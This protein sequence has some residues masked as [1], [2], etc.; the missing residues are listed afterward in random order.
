MNNDCIQ[1]SYTSSYFSGIFAYRV[2]L[3]FN[4]CFKQGKKKFL[5]VLD[6]PSSAEAVSRDLRF[7]T[8][9][10]NIIEFPTWDVLPF[11]A[12]SP[13]SETVASRMHCLSQLLLADSYIAITN[14]SSLMQHLV[15]P[16]IFSLHIVSITTAQSLRRD[17]LVYALDQLGYTRSSIVEEYGQLAVRGAVVDFFS[18]GYAL[19]IRIELFEDRI[20]SI[21]LFEPST[22]RSTQSL[23][24]CNIL[25]ARELFLPL[26]EGKETLKLKVD[27]ECLQRAFIKMRKRCSELLLAQT[28][29]RSLEDAI[30][31]GQA[32]ASIEHLQGF[33][34]EE[35]TTLWSYLPDDVCVIMPSYETL[36]YE[37]KRYEEVVI[38]RSIKAREEGRLHTNYEDSYMGNKDF[39]ASILKHSANTICLEDDASDNIVPV[40]SNVRLRDSLRIS[41][42]QERPLKPLADEIKRR[43]ASNESVCVVVEHKQ[44]A[45]RV[46]DLLSAYDIRSVHIETSFASWC[47]NI[48]KRRAH[49]V[50]LLF[51][52]LGSGFYSQQDG[53]QIIVE[54]EV[55]PESVS[56]PRSRFSKSLRR[57]LGSISQLNEQDYVVHMDYGIGI[58]RGLRVLTIEGADSD[59]LE[60]E[61]AEQAKL[62]VP[63][64]NINKVQKY[65]GQDAQKIVLS[66]LGAKTWENTKQKVKEN[67]A[68]LAGQLLDVMAKRASVIGI[69]Y[70]EINE[71]DKEFADTFPFEPTPDQET[72]IEAVLNDMAVAKPMDRLICGDVGYGKTEVAMRAAFKAANSGRQVAILVPTTVLAEQHYQS[73][74]ERFCQTGIIVKCVSRFY[75]SAENKKTLEMLTSGQ[76]DIII[77]THRLLQKDVSFK[78]LGLLVIDEEHKFGVTH[79]EKLKRFRTEVDVLTLT[80]T[81]IPRTLQLSLSGIRELSLIETAPCDRQAI[82]TSIG[83]YEN[84]IVREAVLRETSRGGQV[85]Y[86]HNRVKDIYEIKKELVELLPEA[87]IAVAHG[88]MKEGELEKVMHSFIQK[89]VDVLLS[90]TIVESGLDIP[91]ANTI[92]IRNAQNFGLAEL[93]QL[94]GRVG[95]SSRRAYAY[96]LIEDMKELNEDTK[97][98]LDVLKSLDDLGVGFRLALQ[99]MEI[100]GAGNLLGKD[101]SGHVQLVGYELYSKILK[102][103]VAQ[104]KVSQARVAKDYEFRPTVECD[105]EIKIGFPAHI[106]SEYVPDVAERLILYQ[107]LIDLNSEEEAEDMR[108]EI[109]DRFGVIPESVSVLLESM[110]FRAQLKRLYVIQ[111]RFRNGTLSLTFHPQAPLQIKKLMN[112]IN[113]NPGKYRLSP[114]MVLSI[115]LDCDKIES[116]RYLTEQVKVLFQKTC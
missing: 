30:V 80:A 41:R 38:E 77:G 65:S 106:P 114:S 3:V 94:R 108:N 84:S 57:L 105:P 96:L 45:A 18:P 67:V 28:A 24:L 62:Y 111:A 98:R 9:F 88:Q 43:F 42:K 97:K 23:D 26:L 4:D 113:S 52:S 36:A 81:P 90:T 110:I 13:S 22:Q 89:E 51:G 25:P 83:K 8:E 39:E 17:D 91:N 64:E 101:Q 92:I 72:A 63:I 116:P 109:E 12:L 33:I 70:D 14:V 99:D 69:K 29:S 103:A 31:N 60:I 34:I 15:S 46:G 27:N 53:L 112:L 82:R 102:D 85:F 10:H 66:K 49:V 16:N 7:F 11:D 86:I 37:A 6:N 93:Y 40:Q 50:G 35:K 54:S 107:R 20:Q 59:F 19:P 76:V 56:K 71:A 48:E 115:V 55:F 104:L 100:R 21:R 44:R 74:H 68:V 32:Y 73:F 78:S 75:S 79:K 95:R 1:T 58:Y 5:V 61:Y 2:S 47:A 87:K